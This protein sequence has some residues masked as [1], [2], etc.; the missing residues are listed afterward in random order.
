MNSN[1]KSKP[2]GPLL[3]FRIPESIHCKGWSHLSWKLGTPVAD[4]LPAFA[5]EPWLPWAS[6]SAR[7][8]WHRSPCWGI[9]PCCCWL[10]LAEALKTANQVLALSLTALLKTSL[11]TG[12]FIARCTHR[13][14]S[15][16]YPMTSVLSGA[17]INR[18][19]V[20]VTGFLRT[21]GRLLWG[22]LLSPACLLSPL[23]CPGKTDNES[24]RGA[25][26]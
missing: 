26:A 24:N 21:W 5:N 4:L 7:M 8:P 13:H 22:L 2:R 11:L 25:A 19:I 20:H 16:C 15:H 3:I 23:H 14:I 10:R 6:S 18:A 17:K 12:S 9:W 1:R